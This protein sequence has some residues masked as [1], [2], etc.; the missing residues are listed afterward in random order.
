MRGA[1]AR[2]RGCARAHGDLGR[3]GSADGGLNPPGDVEPTEPGVENGIGR[4]AADHGLVGGV[5][6]GAERADGKSA[7]RFCRVNGAPCI[8]GDPL[9][10]AIAAW[11]RAT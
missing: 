6:E 4:P 2:A 8:R 10:L 9:P 5:R 3:V 7:L 11:L 1:C